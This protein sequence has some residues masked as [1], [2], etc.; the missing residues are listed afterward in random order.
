M[1]ALKAGVT[2][3][4]PLRAEEGMSLKGRVAYYYSPGAPENGLSWMVLGRAIPRA[5]K[6]SPNVLRG[7]RSTLLRGGNLNL[8]CTLLYFIKSKISSIVKQQIPISE[9]LN[10]ENGKFLTSVQ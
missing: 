1:V 4:G 9:I 7:A 3:L 2:V 8:M 10:C 6:Y 5:E